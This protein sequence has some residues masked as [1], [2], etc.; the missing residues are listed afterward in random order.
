MRDCWIYK[1]YNRAILLSTFMFVILIMT[2]MKH[3]IYAQSSMHFENY[4]TH[5]GLTQNCVLDIIQDSLGLMWMATQDGL[6]QYDG[7]SFFKYDC[8]FKDETKSNSSK[9]GQIYLDCHSKIWATTIEENIKII[10]YRHG[11]EEI[12]KLVPDPSCVIQTSEYQY[13]VGSFTN[14][15]Y[16]LSMRSEPTIINTYLQDISVNS[17][18]KINDVIYASTDAGVYRFSTDHNEVKKIF[19]QFS[20]CN[21]GKTIS[22]RRGY[23]YFF[24]YGEDLYFAPN[25]SEPPQIIDILNDRHQ[26]QDIIIDTK[27]NLWIA[28]Y[29][30][31][32]YKYKIKNAA[33]G[34]YELQDV[35]GI[36]YDD[37]ISIYEDTNGNIWLGSDGGGF[38]RYIN[39]KNPIKSIKNSSVNK[40]AQVNVPRSILPDKKGNVYIGT[41]GKGLVKVN[42]ESNHYEKLSHSTQSGITI[43]DGRVVSLSSNGQDKIFIGTQSQG[44]LVLLPDEKRLLDY[45]GLSPLCIWDIDYINDSTVLLSTRDDG[46]VRFNAHDETFQSL[47]SNKELIQGQSLRICIPE[48]KNGD[49][50]TYLI[51]TDQGNIYR[52]DILSDRLLTTDIDIKGSGGI[53]SLLLVDDELWIGTA[54]SGLI[55][56]DTDKKKQTHINETNTL[57]NNVVY[58]LIHDKKEKVWMSTNQGIVGLNDNITDVS[59]S[60]YQP[61]L[62]N[63]SNGILNNEF[64][65]GAY[66]SD[67]NGNLYFGNIDGVNWFSPHIFVDQES[68]FRLIIKS[69][70]AKN[71]KGEEKTYYVY[72]KSSISIDAGYNNIE[73]HYAL[74]NFSDFTSLQFRSKLHNYE[75][76]WNYQSEALPLRYMNLSPESYELEINCSLYDQAHITDIRRLEF[77]IQ[78]HFYQNRLYHLLLLLIVLG[79]IIY[80]ARRRYIKNKRSNQ[81]KINLAKAQF[82]ALRSQMNPHFL[83]NTL[84]SIKHHALFKDKDE[85]GEYITDFSQLIRGILEYSEKDFISLKDD[86]SWIINY[87]NIENRRFRTPFIFQLDI[88]PNLNLDQYQVPPLIIQPYVENAIWHGLQHKKEDRILQLRYQSIFNGYEIQ[89]IDN[90]IGRKMASKFTSKNSKKSLGLKITKERIDQINNLGSYMISIKIH[91]L[92]DNQNVGT[93]TSIVIQVT[94]EKTNRNQ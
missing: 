83:F 49:I 75:E 8:F 9:L 76:T 3:N 73:I 42:L 78:P 46:L 38:F 41:S 57:P 63:V 80:E 31:G 79:L 66:A 45:T 44:L 61:T 28:T 81:L 54:R 7:N 39:Y 12:V 23:F 93:G 64:N 35:E 6:N 5:D 34:Q 60:N 15:V 1:I 30:D 58:S 16:R 20:E 17:F 43:D 91:D 71:N 21:I 88:D 55:I 77:N 84:N 24:C 2:T 62:F 90:G 32:V 52:Y 56:H 68:D 72:N 47:I 19:S 69:I 53:K 10:D 74:P 36:T 50:N 94:Q 37:I 70:T 25:I 18:S 33:E 26:I 85:T 65:T 67:K 59:L 14:G 4:S 48:Q 87:I 11:T 40:D 86:L 89:I 92:M 22:D 51:G 82:T 27:D 29:G 13:L